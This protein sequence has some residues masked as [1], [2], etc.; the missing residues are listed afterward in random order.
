MIRCVEIAYMTGILPIKKYG[1]Q[2]TLNMFDEISMLDAKGYSK[3]M[4][5]TEEE[6]ENMCGR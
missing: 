3:Y 5:F 1:T 4:G 6:V 2:S